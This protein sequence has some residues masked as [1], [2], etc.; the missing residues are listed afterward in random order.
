MTV[1]RRTLIA[2]AARLAWLPLGGRILSAAQRLLRA[3]TLHDVTTGGA[4]FVWA[5]EEPGVPRVTV[6]RT[7]DFA[8]PLTA[9]ASTRQLFPFETGLSTSLY[10]HQA[11]VTGL[12]PATEYFYRVSVDGSDLSP[13]HRLRTAPLAGPFR[14]LVFGDSGTGLNDQRNVANQLRAETDVSL[15][16]HVGDIVYPFPSI[17]RYLEVHFGMYA[18]LM[19][20]LPFYACAGNHDVEDGGT[21]F[22]AL[23]PSPPAPGVPAGM[24]GFY[25]SFDWGDVHFLALDSNI[26]LTEAKLAP[27]IEWADRDLSATQ[28]AWKVV[29]WHHAPYD[30][31]RGEHRE[32]TAVR[33]RLTP[34]MDKHGVHLV[35]VGH[36]HCYQ[37]SHPLVA[38]KR[39]EA[40]RGTVYVTSGGGGAGLYP[41]P[42]ADFNAAGVSDHHHVS[43]DVAGSRLRLRAVR[44]NGQEIDTA[45]I[46]PLPQ[47]RQ[48]A[49]VNGA[50]FE[51]GIASGGVVTIFGRNLAFT[52]AQFSSV[53]LPVE[54]AGV[55]VFVGDRTLPLLFVSPGQINALLPLDRT[56]NTT[57]RV[58]TANGAAEIAITILETAPAVFWYQGYPAVTHADG[59]QVTPTNPAFPGETLSV[60]L[61]GLGRL[62][63]LVQLGHV[64]PLSPVAEAMARVQVLVEAQ[65]VLPSFSGLSPGSVGLY[66]V[67]FRAP[68][69]LSGDTFPLRIRAGAQTSSPVPLPIA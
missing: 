38:G 35:L 34:L 64:A 58:V 67:N 30:S 3:P 48:D 1:S 42:P 17:R 8:Q 19:S 44:H 45:E 37:R 61:T 50:T 28:K 65:Q 63:Q 18:D 13:V 59:S 15:V 54:L 27:M 49:V 31:L 69:E 41:I 40:G 6:S 62:H 43:V 26:V 11:R 60:F 51:E 53:P 12:Q 25:Y 24:R 33:Q 66:Q 21:A 20:R 32:Q 47:F 57:L 4:T 2:A 16:V 55:R 7:P 52:T 5:T 14:F 29:F 22:L 23:H 56:G 46:I 68:Y 39:V 9:T 10:Q 36:H